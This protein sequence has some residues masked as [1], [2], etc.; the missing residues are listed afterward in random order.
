MYCT[1]RRNKSDSDSDGQ[2]GSN[3]CLCVSLSSRPPAVESQRVNRTVQG[4]CEGWGGPHC[5][6]GKVPPLG[7]QQ[8][9]LYVG[10]GDVWR[11][12]KV[13]SAI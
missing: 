5:S 4:C 13:W 2:R 6:Q 7:V 3:V 9:W 1:I 12:G 11:K 10:R 8:A